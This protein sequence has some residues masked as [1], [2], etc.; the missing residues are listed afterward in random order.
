MTLR[1]NAGFYVL[2]FVGCVVCACKAQG[3]E[4]APLRNQLSFTCDNNFF[5]FDGDDGY[6]TN[7]IFLRY[8]RL[9]ARSANTNKKIIMSYELGQMIFSAHSR[10][11]L[12][13]SNSQ[14]IPYGL[15]QI[16]R[17]IAGYLFGKVT[18]TTFSKKRLLA[19][20]VSV[21]VIGNNSFGK[22]AQEFWHN[23]IGV[24]DYWN[25]V[26][27]Y[28]V[29]NE[30][31]VNLQ[32]TFAQS[33]IHPKTQSTIQIT[34][35]TQAVLGSTFTNLTQSVVLQIGK[36]RAM[37]SSSYWNSRLQLSDAPRGKQSL[38]YF[39]YYKPGIRLQLY[40][41][42]I[43]G[44]MFNSEKGPIVGEIEPLVFSHEF[45][46]RFSSVRYCMGYQMTYQNKE[47]VGQFYDQW[48]ASLYLAFRF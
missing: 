20:G 46:V 35:L 18:Q 9:G 40:N 3:D 5:L 47:A 38:E 36:L 31:G 28:Q 6:Y 12:L 42:T 24:K 21:G 15:N 39:V 11:I 16:D 34:P 2:I 13:N 41:A 45:G 37:S 44:G 8:D 4:V 14:G 23:I 22:E 43:Q 25:W 32:G 48:F 30:W 26:W 1:L 10:K 7:G 19:W 29:K 27:D 17:P 33:L